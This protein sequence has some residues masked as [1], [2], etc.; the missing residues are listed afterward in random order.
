MKKVLATVALMVLLLG[1]IGCAAQ[2]DRTIEE[3]V[4][5]PKGVPTGARVSY[6]FD[7]VHQVGIWLFACSDSSNI[8][9]LPVSQFVNPEKPM[10]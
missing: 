2:S 4:I 8:A 10:K 9:V 7:E 5:S 3:G 6:Y 1:I